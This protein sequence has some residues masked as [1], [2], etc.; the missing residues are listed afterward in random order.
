MV[1]AKSYAETLTSFSAAVSYRR[2]LGISNSK[3]ATTTNDDDVKRRS[4]LK[5][6]GH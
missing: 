6:V 3:G 2:I 5:G 4:P 1:S